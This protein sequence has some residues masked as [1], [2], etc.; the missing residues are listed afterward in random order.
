MNCVTDKLTIGISWLEK[1]KINLN[2]PYQRES[3]VWSTGKQQLFIDS[4]VNNFDIPK[5]YLHDL[6]SRQEPIAY[7]V[8]DGKQRLSAIWN[9]LENQIS[10]ADSFEYLGSEKD[11]PESGKYF[12][13]FSDLWKE[14]FKG[15]S[16]DIVY[17]QDADEQDIEELF[18]RLNNGEAL[19]AAE[20]RNAMGGDMCELIRDISN[21]KFFQKI[22]RFK[23]K[24]Y[25]HYE[26]SAK[27]LKI[28]DTEINTKNR[29]C[30]LKKKFLDN[31]VDDNKRM[32][33]PYKK[34]LTD[35]VNENLNLLCK[36]FEENDPHL[37]RQSY[38]QIYYLFVKGIHNDYAH[39]KLNTMLQE[40]IPKFTL[41]R[42]ENNQKDENERDWDLGEYGRLSQQGTNDLQ[43]MEWRDEILRKFF[44]KWYPEVKI[45]DS[46][47][48]FSD[49]ERHALWIASGKRCSK[50]G[51]EIK[52]EDVDADHI[53]RWSEGGQTIFQN[54]RATCVSCNRKGNN[55]I[56]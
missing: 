1:L 8:I 6:R 53:E 4:L 46:K 19:N 35:Q 23:N 34:K 45:R 30:D 37:S 42:E 2:P 18:S 17:V 22:V 50:C 39:Q 12:K 16:L 24:R 38:P 55:S 54:A 36:V 5:I 9:F 44:L 11:A 28:E 51:I 49:A 52:Y 21:H 15:Q 10:L 20:K 14:R 3:G 41:E 13:D 32:A 40:F 25:S 47:R 43:S 7:A 33:K 29:F 31:L 56:K 26:V 48:N 27:L